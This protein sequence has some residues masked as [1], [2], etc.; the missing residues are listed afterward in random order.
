MMDCSSLLLIIV[1]NIHLPRNNIIY[2]IP[3][4]YPETV[5]GFMNF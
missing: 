1:I 3:I 2:L 5:F 4:L